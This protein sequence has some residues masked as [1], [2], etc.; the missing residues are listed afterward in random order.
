MIERKF[1][2]MQL[3]ATLAALAV[4]FT[5]LAMNA[6]TTRAQQASSQ[7]ATT[8]PVALSVSTEKGAV[9]IKTARGIALS[10]SKAR[11]RFADG[12]TVSSSLEP[13]GQDR[14]D[15]A[16]GAFESQ[17]FKLQPLAAQPTDHSHSFT[18][19]LE[20]RRY[21]KT[22]TVVAFF[23]YD[24]P[25]LAATDS[26]QFVTALSDFA[27]GLATKR[28]KLYWTAPQIV[29]DYRV[30]GP[31]NQ[32]LL[33][34]RLRDEDYHLLVPLAGNG[35]VGEIGVSEI[36]W[37]FEFRVSAASRAENFAPHR[38]PLFAYAASSDPYKLPRE[39][40]ETAFAA[41]EQFG[42]LRWQKGFP[43]T[44]GSLGWCSWN[45]Y[46][47]QV[48]EEKILAS[49]RSIRDRRIPLGFVLVDDGWLSTREGR[50][51]SFDAD[52]QKFPHGLGGLARTLHDEYHVPHVGV[53]HTFQGYWSGVAEGSEIAR[54]H[55]MFRGL[56]DQ[57]LPD[58]RSG[59]GAQFYADWYRG[60]KEAGYDFV[61]VDGQGNT[62][63]FTD[64]LLPLFD[65][66]RGE[67]DNLESAARDNF[68]DASSTRGASRGVSVINCME[69]SLENVYN[70]RDSNAARSSDDYLPDSPQNVKEHVYQNAYNAY[71]LANFAYPDWDMF[72]SHDAHADFHAAARALSGGPVY[73]TDE[74]GKERPEVLRPLALADG[75][76][77]M[78]DEP[79]QVTRD[80]LLTDPASE[81][82][83]LKVFGTVSTQG[84][85]AAT[86]AAFNVNKTASTVVGALRASDVGASV[87]TEQEFA[88]YQRSRQSATVLRDKDAPL[89]FTLGEFGYDIFTVVPVERGVAVFGLLDKY[90]GAAAV[91]SVRQD[92]RTVT[93]RLR[94]AGDFGA[95]A[96]R[97][98]ARVEVDGRV[99]PPRAFSY[100]AGLL[101]I[102]ASSFDARAGERE[103][104]LVMNGRR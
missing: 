50:L 55:K 98:P 24:G 99:L 103:V 2:A 49:A 14:G 18:A 57:L 96:E 82:V 81:P 102:P 38:A 89:A 78:L 56:G 80:L 22:E 20:L 100:R 23:D 61:K 17:R 62:I 74:A 25:A 92:A 93:I 58:P 101:R 15:D 33:W 59:A 65:A 13:A 19:S 40:Y 16:A 94:E 36:D 7:T 85:V 12:S 10:I 104:R 21:T 76:L 83:A 52:A 37:R 97:A 1:R 79:G 72:Q 90:L 86:V 27:R 88:V 5:I 64:G 66:G 60:L 53:W 91:S 28:L 48:S 46:G 35:M 3:L 47:N 26:V 68:G 54:A 31:A 43:A 63:K 4:S 70:W 6:R 77:L 42:R 71:W 45:A 8:G 44:F 9:Q 84:Y 34:R 67:H 87:S 11:L 95:W 39:T 30:L 41:T 75:R 73:F 29:S 32:L 51:T 69:M